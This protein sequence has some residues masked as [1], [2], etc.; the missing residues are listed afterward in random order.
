[1]KD[2]ILNFEIGKPTRN[3]NIY[4]KECFEKLKD[5]YPLLKDFIYEDGCKLSE[6]PHV[7]EKLIIGN[8]SDLNIVNN[9][10][11]GKIN[12]TEEGSHILNFLKEPIKMSPSCVGEITL[13]EDGTKKV[14]INH[15]LH[16]YLS[17]TNEFLE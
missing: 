7:D 4:S 2:V 16:F 5:S 11:I 10:V 3:G 17:D 8:V 15:L 14:K 9:T 13:Q 12:F 6:M 1:M